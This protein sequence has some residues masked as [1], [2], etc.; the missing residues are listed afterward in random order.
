VRSAENFGEE[1]RRRYDALIAAGIRD[2]AQ[3]WRHALLS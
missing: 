3:G 2:I 1:A